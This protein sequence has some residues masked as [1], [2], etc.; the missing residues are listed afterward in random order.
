M[1]RG[2]KLSFPLAGTIIFAIGG[3]TLGGGA[4]VSLSA[5]SATKSVSALFANGGE[6]SDSYAAIEAGGKNAQTWST[7]LMVTG[8]VIATAGVVVAVIT[9]LTG[10][11]GD[12]ASEESGFYFAPSAGGATV[13]WSLRW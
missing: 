8:G 13:G 5:Q 11:G 10:G 6:W 7:V 9:L 4:A 1:L 2:R 12:D 3:A